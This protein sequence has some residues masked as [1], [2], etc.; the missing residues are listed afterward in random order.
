[1]RILW[2]FIA[3]LFK[4]SWKLLNFARQL[5]SNLIF[6]LLVI[7]VATGVLV[8]QQQSKSVDDYRGALY[9][10]LSGIVVDQVSARSP[11]DQFGRDLIG[12]SSS[13]SQE[14]SLF[15]IVDSIRRAKHDAK[16]TGMV[17]KL[18]N[19]LGTD[20]PSMQYI[21]KAINEFKSAGKTVIAISD[22]YSQPQYYLASYANKVYLSPH[23]AVSLHGFS[24]NHLYYKSLLDSL[25]VSTHI[26]RVGTYKSAV[27]P[28]TRD[29]MSEEA[30]LADSLWLNELWNN[31]RNTI[32]V[33]RKIPADKVLPEPTQFIEEFRQAGGDSALYAAKNK[34][35]DEIKP[36]NVI[37]TE[38]SNKFGWDEK[39]KHFNYISL[40]DYIAQQPIKNSDQ[41]NSNIAVIIAEGTIMDG[42]QSEGIVGG[43]TIAEQLR[44]ARLNPNIKAIV[45][46]VNSPGGSI[47]AS[48][49][50]RSELVA[51]REG[52]TVKNKEGHT[53]KENQ[54]PIVVSMG[55]LAASGGYWIST[56]A[57]YIIADKNT[58]TG[59]I[60]VFGVLNTYEKGLNYLGVN[61]DGISTHPL[62]D[63]SVTKGLNPMFS[64]VMQLS[65]ENGYHKFIK[66]VAQS[67]QKTQNEIK[68]IAQGRVWSGSDA[69]KNGLVDQLGD[70]D[71]AVNKAA[72][73]AG[74]KTVSLNWMQ[75][76]LSFSE[77]LMLEF[78]SS[79]Q[80]LLPNALQSMLP[81]PI[82]QIAQDMKQQAVFYNRMNDPQNIYTFCLNC[83]DIH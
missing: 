44:E 78:S 22:G 33:N 63:I 9:V 49:L 24:T 5:I 28:M 38:L 50:I 46:R 20:Q 68:E 62:A 61:T 77:K 69:K 82:A 45:L 32:A 40:Y 81:A 10:D 70:F 42:R 47:S 26:F 29:N 80:A 83:A 31:Y 15:D 64:D 8:Y 76:E 7:V 3:A 12:V 27:E 53:V 36:R 17:L 14:T 67:R 41:S 11:L 48:E 55:G 21:G 18:D 25:K 71:D 65:I 43:D 75:P 56:P 74:I 39:N 13:S 35:V 4:W 58:L 2:K 6:I 51:I 60:G 72:Q 34:L 30:R 1:M 16:I 57:N 23:G 59:S 54:K 19:F 79:A 66:L 37:E 52:T 73:L